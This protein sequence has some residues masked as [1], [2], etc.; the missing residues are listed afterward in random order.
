[1]INYQE[2]VEPG[3][4]DFEGSSCLV[5]ASKNEVKK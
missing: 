1:M 4:N 5:P 2:A 3:K